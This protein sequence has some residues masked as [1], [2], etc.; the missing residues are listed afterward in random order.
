MLYILVHYKATNK[1]YRWVIFTAWIVLVAVTITHHMTD[2]V[3]VGILILWAATS[4]FRDSSGNDRV[5]LAAIALFGIFL[6][7]AYVFLLK[8]N[9]V[10]EYSPGILQVHLLIL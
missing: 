3:F 9:P 8:G 10:I 1:N 2:Y 7:L 4:L 5:R 6:S